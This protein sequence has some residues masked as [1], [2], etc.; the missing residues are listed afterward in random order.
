MSIFANLDTGAQV[1]AGSNS[2][3]GDFTRWIDTLDANDYAELVHL[4]EHGWCQ[5]LPALTKQLGKAVES[6]K[7][8]ADAANIGRAVAMLASSGTGD[9]VMVISNGMTP[10]DGT[11]GSMKAVKDWPT[12]FS[13]LFDDDGVRAAVMGRLAAMN[14]PADDTTL[15]YLAGAQ[16]GD[17]VQSKPGPNGGI[18]IHTHG[19]GYVTYSAARRVQF[20][21]VLFVENRSFSIPRGRLGDGYG[22][23]YFLA[24]VDKLPALGVKQI[25]LIAPGPVNDKPGTGGYYLWPLFGFDGP[26]P[27]NALRTLP[28]NYQGCATVLD[29]YDRAGGRQWWKEHGDTIA[30]VFDL[31]G[32]SLSQEVFAAFMKHRNLARDEAKTA[33]IA[34]EDSVAQYGPDEDSER[35]DIG[36]HDLAALERVWDRRSLQQIFRSLGVPNGE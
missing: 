26:L 17:T 16:I 4:V 22:V 9:G 3:W 2:G 11:E 7:P 31:S 30:L 28:D 36:P 5:D 18:D 33:E 6:A 15:A 29:L 14:L 8:D 19:A 20:D 24:Q 10:D 27:A 12:G 34:S 1:Q 35:C 23:E 25:M 32:G 21:G 13:V